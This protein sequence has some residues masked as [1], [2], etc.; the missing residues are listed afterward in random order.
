VKIP[1][2]CYARGISGMGALPLR[3]LRIHRDHCVKNF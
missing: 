2:A 3:P 1:F